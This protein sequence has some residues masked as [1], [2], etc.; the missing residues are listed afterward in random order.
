MALKAMQDE[1]QC[2]V[3]SLGCMYAVN[4]HSSVDLFS[5]D[6]SNGRRPSADAGAQGNRE[7][8]LT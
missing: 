5:H 1:R 4:V 2:S 8:A 6:P 7:R 3:C